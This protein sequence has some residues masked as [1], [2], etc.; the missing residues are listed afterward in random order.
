MVNTDTL[1]RIE[2]CLLFNP[3]FDKNRSSGNWLAH[4]PLYFL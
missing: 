1:Y 2:E 4:F 3:G